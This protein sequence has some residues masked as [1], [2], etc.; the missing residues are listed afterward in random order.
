MESSEKNSV[1]VKVL[2]SGHLDLDWSEWFSGL[3]TR[4]NKEGNSLL[5]GTLQDQAAFFGCMLC[6]R[7]LGLDIIKIEANLKEEC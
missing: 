3:K 4:H 1:K 7:D 2:I 5:E 6:L